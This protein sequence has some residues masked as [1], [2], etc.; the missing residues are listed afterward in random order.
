MTSPRIKAFQ[1]LKSLFYLSKPVLNKDIVVSVLYAAKKYFLANV[2]ELSVQFITD[3]APN[4]FSN[5][6]IVIWEA[7]NYGLKDE[8]TE[9]THSFRRN[10]PVLDALRNR[11]NLFAIRGAPFFKRMWHILNKHK[12]NWSRLILYPNFKLLPLSVVKLSLKSD[13]L[14][15]TEEILWKRSI[16]WAKHQFER[17]NSAVRKLEGEPGDPLLASPLFFFPSLTQYYTQTA[18]PMNKRSPSSP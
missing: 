1:Y 14:T 9:M 8:V 7:H 2:Y 4:D 5:F 18:P 3:L 10:G 13:D 6:L 16:F 15:L 12:T 17:E 11:K